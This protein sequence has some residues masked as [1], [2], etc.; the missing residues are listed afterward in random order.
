MFY[1]TESA[2]S[3]L[4]LVDCED[5]Q[6][7]RWALAQNDALWSRAG[8]LRSRRPILIGSQC[9]WFT[10]LCKLESLLWNSFVVSGWYVQYVWCVLYWRP[11]RLLFAVLVSSTCPIVAYNGLVS[12]YFQPLKL[13]V[14]MRDFSKAL[15]LV[16]PSIQ[17]ASDMFITNKK[18]ISWDD[19]GGLAGVK[20]KLIQ[21]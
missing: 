9:S 19:I 15:H 6:W 10:E 20:Q 16:R 17:G 5:K 4:G 12:I 14:T 21:V 2:T 3:N 1:L 13:Q 18:P 7:A 11:V 8:M